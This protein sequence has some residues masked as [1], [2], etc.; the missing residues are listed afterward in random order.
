MDSPTIIGNCIAVVLL[1]DRYYKPWIEK[2][3]GR[4]RKTSRPGDY[5]ATIK[6][7]P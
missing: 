4:A 3:R 6:R 1:Y 7:K 2:S 5:K